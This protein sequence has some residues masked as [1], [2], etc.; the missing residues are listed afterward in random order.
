VIRQPIRAL[1]LSLAAATA[2]VLLAAIMSPRL[3]APS[4]SAAPATSDQPTITV[5]G[6]SEV[7]AEPD[8]AVVSVGATAVASTAQEAMEDVS[9]RLTAIIAGARGQGIQERDIQTAGISLQPIYRPRRG[10]DDTPPEIQGYRAS[11]NVSLTVRDLNRASAVLDAALANG[12]NVMGGLRF[13][14]SS[15][16]ALQRQALAQATTNAQAKAEAIATASGLTITGVVSINEDSVSSPT[17]RL[18]A[19]GR[20]FAASDAAAP[21]VQGGE[22][23]IRATV[24]ATYGV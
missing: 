17:P 1:S 3:S 22:L 9:T 7:R 13:S 14:L 10:D 4:A 19:A 20:A 21:P 12:A 18:E 6:T 11:N 2:V 24:R 5:T 15:M 16:D 23:T 8:M